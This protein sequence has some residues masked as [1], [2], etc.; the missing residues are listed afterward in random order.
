[1]SINIIVYSTTNVIRYKIQVKVK[2]IIN[3]FLLFND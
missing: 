1:M 2:D 3:F